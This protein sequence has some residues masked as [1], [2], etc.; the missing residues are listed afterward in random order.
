MTYFSRLRWVFEQTLFYLLLFFG[1]ITFG[2]AIYGYELVLEFF[3]DGEY[4]LLPVLYGSLGMIV[5]HLIIKRWSIYQLLGALDHELTHLFIAVLFFRNV[6]NLSVNDSGS[7]TVFIER[8]S[9]LI[10]LAPYTFSLAL[11]ILVIVILLAGFESMLI[12]S[13]LCGTI[14]TYQ[15]VRDLSFMRKLPNDLKET[16]TVVSLI[17]L[18]TWIPLV[19]LLILSLALFEANGVYRYYQLIV[20]IYAEILP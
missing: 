4:S 12:Q 20:S 13:I 5:L 18:L 16:G 17:W 19:D 11:P 6:R 9:S 8:P 1:V 7:G 3:G 14:L 10:Y 15:I 2:V